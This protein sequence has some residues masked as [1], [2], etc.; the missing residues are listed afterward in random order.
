V[1]VVAELNEQPWALRRICG[2]ARRRFGFLDGIAGVVAISAGLTA[3]AE[4]EA[5]RLKR[6]LRVLELPI[7]VDVDE[8]VPTQYGAGPEMLVYAASPGYDAALDFIVEAMGYVWQEH[9]ACRLVVTGGGVASGDSSSAGGGTDARVE[10]AGYV[11]RGE[12]LE[13]YAR[14]RALLIPLG[15]DG[16]SRARFPSKIGEYLAAAR[17]VVTSRVGE[18]GRHLTD[19]VTAYVASPGDAAA[20]AARIVELLEHP[21][22][23]AAVGAAGRRLAEERFHY[24]SHGARLRSLI[25]SLG[26]GGRGGRC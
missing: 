15:D 21:E 11:G 16:R 7:V 2:A 5:R 8:Q 23:A 19:G 4:A 22:Q 24:S 12:L 25:E 10:F 6:R 3:W 17:P 20:Y 9:P 1:P 14:A 18:I 26:D 13:L